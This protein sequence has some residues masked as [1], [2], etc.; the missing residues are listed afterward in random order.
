MK[1]RHF[2]EGG[3]GLKWNFVTE[4]LNFKITI[5]KEKYQLKKFRWTFVW[6]ILKIIMFNIGM[7]GGQVEAKIWSQY[8]W[9]SPQ[10][11][12]VLVDKVPSNW[13]QIKAVRDIL[14]GAIIIARPPDLSASYSEDLPL[15]KTIK[16]QS[17]ISFQL[18]RCLSPPPPSFIYVLPP[19]L[20]MGT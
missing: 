3:G 19:L 5:R 13:N 18:Q 7:G 10:E 1:F 16:N 11:G 8:T 4:L 6:D 2:F 15:T 9:N 12:W 20:T 14:L 17:F